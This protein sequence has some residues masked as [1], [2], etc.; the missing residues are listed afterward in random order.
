MFIAVIVD[1]DGFRFVSAW[2]NED[3]FQEVIATSLGPDFA[4]VGLTTVD[5]EV[6]PALSM[7]I[8]GGA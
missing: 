6:A 1:G 8:P 7:A 5:I 2:R 4:A 3:A